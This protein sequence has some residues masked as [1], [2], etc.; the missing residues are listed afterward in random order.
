MAG[1]PS[2]PLASFFVPK[3]CLS[4]SPLPGESLTYDS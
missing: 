3:I 2:G 1:G 4:L